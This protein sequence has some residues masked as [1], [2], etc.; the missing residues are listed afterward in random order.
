M[1]AE[2]VFVRLSVAYLAG[3]FAGM[4]MMGNIAGGIRQRL[5]MTPA[6]IGPLGQIESGGDIAGIGMH[7]LSR[8]AIHAGH[9]F[10]FIVNIRTVL[11]IGTGELSMHSAA[12]AAGTGGIHG[13]T[14]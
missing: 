6:T 10:T 1:A 12:M 2:T 7:L 8:M 13:R 3:N 9:L 11:I 5:D 14:F 4:N